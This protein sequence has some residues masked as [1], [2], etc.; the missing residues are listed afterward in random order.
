VSK[1]DRLLHV[2]QMVYFE[3]IFN[4]TTEQQQQKEKILLVPY[5]RPVKKRRIFFRDNDNDTIENNKGDYEECNEPVKVIFNAAANREYAS[6]AFEKL[7]G[8]YKLKKDD[9]DKVGIPY[10]CVVSEEDKEVETILNNLKGLSNKRKGSREWRRYIDELM[11]LTEIVL[12]RV[13][14]LG[15]DGMLEEDFM[16][17]VMTFCRYKDD[18]DDLETFK[19]KFYDAWYILQ[20]TASRDGKYDEIA[21]EAFIEWKKEHG[22]LA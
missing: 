7:G 11:P 15:P 6:E 20:E 22:Y 2:L 10:D 18:K 14:K 9:F 4:Q 16:N 21:E 12:D 17:E 8:I 19:T 5:V 1:I 3:C 13:G